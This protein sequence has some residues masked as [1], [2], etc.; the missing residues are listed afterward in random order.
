MPD[1]LSELL[2]IYA[3]E[4]A[5]HLATLNQALLALETSRDPADQ[6]AKIEALGRAAHSLKG[7]SRAVGMTAVEII[8]HHM[9]SV[10]DTIERGGLTLSPST[11]D[12]LYDAFDSL[13]AILSG[14]DFELEPLITALDSIKGGSN[15]D[16]VLPPAP[17]KLSTASRSESRSTHPSET[18]SERIQGGEAG[19]KLTD[20]S[21]RVSIHKL[22]SLMADASDLLVERGSIEQRLNEVKALRKAHQRWQKEWRR[23]RTA[24]I[25]SVRQASK[26]NSADADDQND[27]SALIDFLNTTQRYMRATG[28]QLLLLDRML[29]QDNLRISMI[30]DSLQ[31]STRRVRLVPFDLH[32]SAF[33]RTVRDV[34]RQENK[35][36]LLQISGAALELDKRVLESIKDPLI[37]LLRNAVDHGI[38]SPDERERRGKPREGTIVMAISQ[39]GGEMLLIVADDGAGIDV[40]RVRRSAKGILSTSEVD[41]MPD[42]DALLLIMLPGL[43]TSEKVTTISGR[44]IGL[45]IV[46]ENIEALQ[47]RITI[48]S[49]PGQ[50]TTFRLMLPT[51]LSTMRCMLIRIGAETYA[52]PTTAIE[53]IVRADDAKRFT[54]GGR[55]MMTVDGRSIGLVALADVIERPGDERPDYAMILASADR[56]MAFLLDDLITESEM[57]VKSLNPELAQTR[58]VA[59]ATLLGTGEVVIIL[60]VSDLIKTAQGA[61]LHRPERV[62]LRPAEVAA[63]YRILVVDDS[64][65]TRTLEKNILEAAGYDVFTATNGLEALDLLATTT[66]DLIVSDV[67]MPYLD[68]LE[69]TRRIRHNDR[70]SGLPVILVTS[71]EAPEQRER[72]LQVGANRYIVKGGF[73][74]PELLETIRQLL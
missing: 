45:D 24:Y 23:V 3:E 34:A 60:N 21:I 36:V 1:D 35:E 44:G 9:E 63:T 53:G 17:P 68:G 39:R 12:I 43:S 7:A 27:W 62:A 10:F 33:Q 71:L 5:E 59:G 28:Q 73:D 61:I 72:G 66:C 49:T 26:T 29:A 55:S 11:A 57:V 25:R 15:R 41:A 69:M 65:T 14:E 16:I 52:I 40:A 47:G 64:L 42:S 38:E 50:G 13:E 4:A 6:R 19:F 54:S 56:R 32:A 67:E 20:E 31:D 70:L 8:S 18:Y 74:Q 22:D 46:R 30:A 51:S 2:A 37:H 48:E 58:H